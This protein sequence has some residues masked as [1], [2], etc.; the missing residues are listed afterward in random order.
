MATTTKITLSPQEQQLV[1][2]TEWIL[3]KRNII[4]KVY[5]LLG[6]FSENSK[7]LAEKEKPL[8][9]ESLFNTEPKIY[10]GENYRM[11]PY[12]LL[13]YPRYFDKENVFAIRTMFWWGNFFSITLHLSGRYKT[14]FEQPL[15]NKINS[16]QHDQYYICIN[17]DQWQHHFEKD[18]YISICELDKE[19]FIQ[20]TGAAS[21]I[22]ISLP[23]ALTQW[24]EMPNL[25]ERSFLAILELLKP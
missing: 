3:T 4:D 18:N 22:K 6:D 17:K 2:N 15:S 16:L 23:F 19:K 13:D 25:L 8:L 14:M 9:T 11:L 10:K 20:I 1:N 7:L 5:R 21:F 24:D 12:V